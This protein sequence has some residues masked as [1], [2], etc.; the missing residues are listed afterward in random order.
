MEEK[1]LTGYPS[2]DK[3]WLKYYSKE[4]INA[5]MPEC[6]IYEYLW[7]S[8]KDHLNDTALWYFDRKISFSELFDNIE[9]T[10]KAFTA[11][12][13]KQGD[14]VVMATV[15][16]PE[17]IYAVYALNRLGAVANMIDPRTSVE[18]IKEY[19]SEVDAKNV[20][21]I[22]VAY[23][24]IEKAIDDTT[25][26]KIIIASPADSLP[27]PKKF[28]F[29]MLNKLKG[30]VPKLGNNCITWPDMLSAGKVTTLQQLHISWMYAV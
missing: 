30:S 21:C 22:D 27:Q 15:T 10:A 28:L 8:N 16:T 5:T 9:K 13:I 12:G 29:N 1:K 25:V 18:G 2:I 26:E 17:T 19:I 7:E 6:T 4:A 24:K 23:P 20:L 3:P 14:I 11:A